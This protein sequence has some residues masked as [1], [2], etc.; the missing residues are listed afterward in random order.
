[1]PPDHPDELPVEAVPAE[2]DLPAEAELLAQAEALRSAT[3]RLVRQI[4]RRTQEMPSG[5]AA[6]LGHLDREGRLAITDLADRQQVRHQSMA[7]TVK[8]LADQVLVDLCPDEGDRRRVIVEITELGHS[9][10]DHQRRHRAA[11]IA[12]AIST[13][14]A[15]QRE[16]LKA[17]PALLDALTEQIN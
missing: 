10:L 12:A 17:V 14:P 2:A 16:T 11:T 9:R 1:M 7:R 3:G 6:V 8:L 13:L 5:Q 15:D 4:V